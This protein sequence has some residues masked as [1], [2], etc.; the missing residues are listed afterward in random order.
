MNTSAHATSP[1]DQGQ[2]L[3]STLLRDLDMQGI[4]HTKEFADR[5]HKRMMEDAL[6]QRWQEQGLGRE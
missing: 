5:T 4:S 1:I 6:L 3:Y 2:A